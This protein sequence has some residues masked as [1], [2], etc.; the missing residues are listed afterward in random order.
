MSNRGLPGTDAESKGLDTRNAVSVDSVVSVDNVDSVD[1][2]DSVDSAKWDFNRRI[3][4]AVCTGE[5]KHFFVSFLRQQNH[6]EAPQAIIITP[7]TPADQFICR[8]LI[9]E[10]FP[11]LFLSFFVQY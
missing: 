5:H 1:Y 8:S 6:S 3:C 10:I 9:S 7:G 11:E 4:V 2:V